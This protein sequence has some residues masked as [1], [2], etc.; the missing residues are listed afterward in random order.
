MPNYFPSIQKTI[1]VKKGMEEGPDYQKNINATADDI[2]AAY[3]ALTAPEAPGP[4][5]DNTP[6]L[7][8]YSQSQ[9]EEGLGL[10]KDVGSKLRH[11]HDAQMVQQAQDDS[12]ADHMHDLGNE[13]FGGEEDDS[14]DKKAKAIHQQVLQQM[15]NKKNNGYDY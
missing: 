2:K 8:N 1:G 11:A 3:R 12:D 7:S 10:Q 9:R 5:Q 14:N 6:N 15:I 4:Q 13:M